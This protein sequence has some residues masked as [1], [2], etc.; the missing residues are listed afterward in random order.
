VAD[1]TVQGGVGLAF[2]STAFLFHV[3]VETDLFPDRIFDASF[4]TI[5]DK[6]TAPTVEQQWE[7]DHATDFVL[8]P[9]GLRGSNPLGQQLDWRDW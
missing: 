6:T 9:G 5:T 3:V 7:D 2:P 1:D 8:S 4:G